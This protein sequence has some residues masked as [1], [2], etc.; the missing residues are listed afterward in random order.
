MR[1]KMDNAE[2]IYKRSMPK[3]DVRRFKDKKIHINTYNY[4]YLG[5]LHTNK[6]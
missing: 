3:I 1:Y 6:G 2:I 5:M 4:I